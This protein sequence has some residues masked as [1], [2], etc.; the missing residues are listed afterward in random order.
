MF[1]QADSSKASDLEKGDIISMGF[2]SS[3]SQQT[4]LSSD[5]DTA[6]MPPYHPSMPLLE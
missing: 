2:P 1:Q 4:G 6:A 5:L 3:H